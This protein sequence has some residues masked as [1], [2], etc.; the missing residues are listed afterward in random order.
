[1]W[2]TC[3]KTKLLSILK[4]KTQGLNSY[5]IKFKYVFHQKR[6]VNLSLKNMPQNSY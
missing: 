5:Y 1:M 2:H 3:S 6:I 4:T